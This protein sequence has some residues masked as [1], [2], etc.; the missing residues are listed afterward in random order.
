MRQPAA[1]IKIVPTAQQERSRVRTMA[2]FAWFAVVLGVVVACDGG[3]GVAGGDAAPTDAVVTAEDA[4]T[5]AAPSDGAPISDAPSD[6]PGCAAGTWT[7]MPIDTVPIGYGQGIV[8]D[9]AGGVHVAY[10]NDSTDSL[11]HAYLAS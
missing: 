7:T 2:R 4:T 9:A 1:V 11:M 6:A 3:T 8:V 5:D 10:F